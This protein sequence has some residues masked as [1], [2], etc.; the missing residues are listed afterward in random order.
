MQ[1]VSTATVSWLWHPFGDRPQRRLAPHAHFA[2]RG[3][4]TR[5]LVRW[6][7]AA[8]Y[9]QVWWPA[10]AQRRYELDRLPRWDGDTGTWRDPDSGQPLST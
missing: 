3:T 2:I 1:E 4:I 5:Q 10:C 9:H 7:A 6:V 8:T